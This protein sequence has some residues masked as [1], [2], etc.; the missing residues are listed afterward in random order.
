MLTWLWRLLVVGRPSAPRIS[1]LASRVTDVEL[2]L[3]RM[4]ERLRELNA[5]ITTATRQPRSRQDAPQDTNDEEPAPEPTQAGNYPR[6]S[7]AH[8]ARR[9]RT[10]G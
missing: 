5:R 2:E 8:L 9:F 7:T 3:A 1:A 4:T 10:G 6:I